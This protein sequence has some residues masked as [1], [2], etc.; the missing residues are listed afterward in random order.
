[1]RRPD[2]RTGRPFS[3][4]RAHIAQGFALCNSY[5]PSKA[6][7]LVHRGVQGPSYRTKQTQCPHSL[8]DFRRNRAARF[9]YMHGGQKPT[10][11]ERREGH[12]RQQDER[13]AKLSPRGTRVNETNPSSPF[14]FCA[15]RAT[16]GMLFAHCS[17][18]RFP[19]LMRGLR[20]IMTR[21]HRKRKQPASIILAGCLLLALRL[22][23]TQLTLFCSVHPA[24]TFRRMS[25][26]IV[27]P[28]RLMEIK[29]HHHCPCVLS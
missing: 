22:V 23:R 16:E 19:R 5:L 7:G 10:E 3:I 24:G 20:I 18:L 26:A 8:S 1:M 11:Y 29:V 27:F 14:L 15:H 17:T 28:M 21:K 13:Q 25:S 12:G 4:A 9:G 6:R 2:G